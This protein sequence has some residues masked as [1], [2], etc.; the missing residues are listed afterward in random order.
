MGGITLWLIISIV[1]LVIDISTSS[2]LFIWFTLGGLGAIIASLLGF[3]S[4]IQVIVFLVISILLI[5]TAYPIVKN[6]ARV[7]IKGI[8]S[9]EQRYIGREILL[10][11]DL[12]K[13]TQLKIEGIYWNV[14]NEG[15]II[16]KGEKATIIELR[17]NKLIVKKL[18]SK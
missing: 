1:A 5:L 6:K 12:D 15:E 9:R 18:N 17:G 13:E 3:S 2:F 7:S 16:R 14:E 11:K 10:D 8:A 4:S